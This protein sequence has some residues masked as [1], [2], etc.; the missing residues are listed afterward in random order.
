MGQTKPDSELSKTSFIKTFILPA[1]WVFLIPILSL[2][3]FLHA[4]SRFDHRVR[5]NMIESVKADQQLTDEQRSQ[6]LE[7]VESVPMS[8]M[9]LHPE[10]AKTVPQELRNYYAWFR[11]MIRLSLGSI[12]AGIAVFALGGVCV[13]ASYRSQWAQYYSLSLGWQILRLYGALQTIALG[14]MVVA[15]SFWVTALWFNFY[16]VKLIFIAG[17]LAIM[18]VFSV[19]L[20]IFRNP[21]LDF[22]VD[23][24]LLDPGQSSALWSRL[25]KICDRVGTQP[26]DQIIAGI[27]DNFF[28][29]EQAVK[30]EGK[31]VSGRTLFISLALLKQ[32]QSAEADAILAH[33]M[34]HFSGQD[35]MYSKRIAPLLLR[36]DNYLQALANGALTLP[37]YYFMLCFRAMY[38]LSLGSLSRQREFRADRIA[39]DVTSPDDLAAAL[40]RTVAYS[41]YRFQVQNELFKQERALASANVSERVEQGFPSFAVG[42]ASDPELTQSQTAHPFD[43]HPPLGKRLE[44][45]NI[46]DPASLAPA[47]LSNSGDAGWYYSI[48]DASTLEHDQWRTFEDQ[49]RKF[50][51]QTL[52][53]RFLPEGAEEEAIVQAAFPELVF[54]G[55]DGSA[56]VNFREICFA[57]QS[58][59]M[60]YSDIQQISLED[61]VLTFHLLQSG[62]KSKV[63]CKTK[64]FQSP[65]GLVEAVGRYLGRYQAA[66]AYQQQKKLENEIK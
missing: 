13:V 8:R 11:N 42:F 17:A 16:S 5:E 40:L 39:A 65:G 28:V 44:A 45:V 41:K 64:R 43:S 35:T 46:G 2:L 14:A 18:A 62:K 38:Q 37:I 52:A 58:Q 60:L 51:E 63:T 4:Q 48:D 22:S 30:V 31:Q 25:R 57:K 54:E 26:P 55:K 1:L 34:A 33:E 10:F 7:I 32:L 3:F 27:D 50:H 24:K 23:G 15:L 61:G 29:T 49:F 21:K 6:E 47:V 66:L 53:Y 19:L 59:V 56:T 20:G 36:Y 12:L 9:I